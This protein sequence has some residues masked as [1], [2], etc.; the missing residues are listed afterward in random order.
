VTAAD[1]E[2]AIQTAEGEVIVGLG[3]AS[4][5]EGFALKVGDEVTIAGFYEDDEFKAGTIENL[6]TGQ[7][8]TLRNETGRPMWAG[9]GRLQNQAAPND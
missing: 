1:N 5:R 7:T 9:R 2:I 6:T 8:I 4:Y 3:Q